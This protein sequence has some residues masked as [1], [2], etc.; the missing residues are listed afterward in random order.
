MLTRCLPLPVLF[1]LM[2]APLTLCSDPRCPQMV[3][4]SFACPHCPQTPNLIALRTH[5]T[6]SHKGQ[7]VASGSTVVDSGSA[8]CKPPTQQVLRSLYMRFSFDGMPTCSK[9][10]RNFAAWPPF[11]NHHH[12]RFCPVDALAP[13]R[14]DTRHIKPLSASTPFLPLLNC[15]EPTGFRPGQLGLPRA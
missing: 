12:T 11:F 9:C 10:Q 8:P 15:C 1:G 13:V 7:Q 4:R 6:R 14:T 3:Q 2:M 5:C